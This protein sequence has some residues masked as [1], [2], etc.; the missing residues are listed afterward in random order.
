[1]A[2]VTLAEGSR[3]N[4]RINGVQFEGLTA[5]VTLSPNMRA[6][7][8]NMLGAEITEETEADATTTEV[9]VDAA[10][11]KREEAEKNARAPRGK[12]TP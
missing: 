6:Y 9:D 4:Q 1:M 8:I 7:F 3:P 10:V 12:R 5:E 2:K 11:E